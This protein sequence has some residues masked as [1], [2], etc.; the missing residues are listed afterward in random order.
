VDPPRRLHAADR[1][2]RAHAAGRGA[3]GRQ[4][5]ADDGSPPAKG[6]KAV[7]SNVDRKI[8]VPKAESS[9]R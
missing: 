1:P 2:R 7:A 5:A 4:P 3:D 8:G 6:L 9:R